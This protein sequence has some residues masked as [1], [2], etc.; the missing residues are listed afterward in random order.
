MHKPS[1]NDKRQ[2]GRVLSKV[3]K[4]LTGHTSER[5]RGINT[6]KRLLFSKEGGTRK[7]LSLTSMDE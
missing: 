2:K 1:V 7:S 4:R 6:R 5:G 3:L